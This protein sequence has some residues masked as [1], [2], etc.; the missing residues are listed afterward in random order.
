MATI[1]PVSQGSP[2]EAFPFLFL[3]LELR[4]MIYREVL[5]RCS[6]VLTDGLHSP[7]TSYS[8]GRRYWHFCLKSPGQEDDGVN[9]LRTCKRIHAELHPLVTRHLPSHL[10]LSKNLHSLPRRHHVNFELG[11]PVEY[12]TQ[13]SFN[14]ASLGENS[15]GQG[16]CPDS[17]GLSGSDFF[18]CNCPAFDIITFDAPPEDPHRLP[19]LEGIH[20][21]SSWLN[22][23]VPA[24]RE[25]HIYDTLRYS[26]TQPP[27]VCTC[28]VAGTES[29][30]CG[31]CRCT[32]THHPPLP[33]PETLSMSADEV[34]ARVHEALLSRY[35]DA[36][37]QKI[38]FPVPLPA[39]YQSDYSTILGSLAYGVTIFLHD[40]C[41]VAVPI[42][43]NR[44]LHKGLWR[45]TYK[46]SPPEDAQEPADPPTE[47]PK[48]PRQRK[49]RLRREGKEERAKRGNHRRA[50]QFGLDF[51]DLEANDFFD[52]FLN[53]SD[54]FPGFDSFDG[55]RRTRDL[56]DG[57]TAKPLVDYEAAF[58]VEIVDESVFDAQFER[59][60][61]ADQ[62][63]DQDQTN[64]PADVISTPVAALEKQ[65]RLW[66]WD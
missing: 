13:L 19:N 37:P 56:P 49:D 46:L 27:E 62:G 48:T 24:L 30:A 57:F 7:D 29:C 10:I 5:S 12:I 64:G 44:V 59:V 41:E 53:D 40:D 14:A 36:L 58:R 51:G 22:N 50:D 17:P 42:D 9:L 6:I 18:L 20:G 55:E 23:S 4:Y 43:A 54:I 25:I 63:Q 32:C 1:E 8:C 45:A 21:L 60:T 38:L 33:G 66:G 31:R 16:R 11:L 39:P 61:A 65:Q 15:R 52:D 3:H 47:H 26:L 2:S 28:P 35:R 34:K